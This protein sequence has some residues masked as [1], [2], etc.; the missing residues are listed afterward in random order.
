[1]SKMISKM[2]WKIYLNVNLW[3]KTY[4]KSQSLS[5]MLVKYFWYT[6]LHLPLKCKFV[7]FCVICIYIVFGGWLIPYKPYIS[8]FV[9]LAISYFFLSH[10]IN[11]FGGLASSHFEP[12]F[13]VFCNFWCI[14]SVWF[15]N[16]HYSGN[17]L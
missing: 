12:L 11:F 8:V 14:K 3:K 4:S 2:F 13:I 1:M 5:A 10:F 16:I 7:C 15:R 9:R 6:F 17:D